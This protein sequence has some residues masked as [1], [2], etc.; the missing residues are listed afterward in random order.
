M[1]KRL[2]LV[3]L[4]CP[5]FFTCKKWDTHTVQYAISGSGK[6]NIS[7]VDGHGKTKTVTDADSVWAAVFPSDNGGMLLKLNAVSQ[8]GRPT[9]GKIIIDLQE[10]AKQ[11]APGGSISISAKLP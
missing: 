10:A 6:Y 3:L 11:Y 4:L 7:Y 9:S 5:L 2:L 8:D 1:K